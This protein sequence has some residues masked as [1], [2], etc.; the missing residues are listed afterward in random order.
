MIVYKDVISG[1]EVETI[2]AIQIAVYDEEM[3]AGLA[4]LAGT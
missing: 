4:E 2:T 1:D 3:R